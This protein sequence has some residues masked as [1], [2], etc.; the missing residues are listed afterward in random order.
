MIITTTIRTGD[1]TTTLITTTYL[2]KEG[3][4]NKDNQTITVN[5]R[6]K[7]IT[8]TIITT[9]TNTVTTTLTTITTIESQSANPE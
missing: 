9:T 4:N 3:L 2:H 5:S 1:T 7:T 8:T 6:N